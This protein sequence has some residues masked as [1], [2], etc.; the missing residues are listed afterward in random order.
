MVDAPK[1]ADDALAALDGIDEAAV[2]VITDTTENEIHFGKKVN[3]II[4]K[5]VKED[6]LIGKIGNYMDLGPGQ[7]NVKIQDI[8]NGR[9]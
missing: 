8:A 5:P 6:E 7:D 4:Q 9:Q 2:I 1:N 3:E